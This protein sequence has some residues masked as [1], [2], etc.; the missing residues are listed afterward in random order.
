MSTVF[1]SAT[2]SSPDTYYRSFERSY[3]GGP[4]A[5]EIVKIGLGEAEIFEPQVGSIELVGGSKGGLV[6]MCGGRPSNAIGDDI[7][8]GFSRR[9]G[10]SG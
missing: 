5:V 2:A 3:R 1:F 7:Y 6:S 10:L 8:E 4:D 9:Q